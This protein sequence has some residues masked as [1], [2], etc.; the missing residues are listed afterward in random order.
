MFVWQLFL[1]EM[2]GGYMHQASVIQA[3]GVLIFTSWREGSKQNKELLTVL[4]PTTKTRS[5]QKAGGL[6]HV[7]V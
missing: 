7:S 1:Q 2:S 3:V 5:F 6:V 4:I